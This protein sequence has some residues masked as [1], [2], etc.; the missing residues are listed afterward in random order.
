MVSIKVEDLE[1]GYEFVTA[2]G[3]IEV[4]MGV[5]RDKVEFILSRGAR[6]EHRMALFVIVVNTTTYCALHGMEFIAAIHT[7]NI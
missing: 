7:S 6:R 3:S 2:G 5:T 1:R 4:P